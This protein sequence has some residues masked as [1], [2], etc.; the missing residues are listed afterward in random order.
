MPLLWIHRVPRLHS[1]PCLRAAVEL[2][3]LPN[4]YLA[5]SCSKLV[6][7]YTF[8]VSPG[9]EPY[10]LHSK[11]ASAPAW[12]SPEQDPTHKKGKDDKARPASSIFQLFRPGGGKY[13]FNLVGDDKEVQVRNP[14][15]AHGAHLHALCLHDAWRADHSVY[16]WP[17]CSADGCKCC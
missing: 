12:V 9:G 13:A 5:P 16:C 1:T 17:C 15:I 11:V 10:L 2:E 4:D 8:E 7:E 14:A 6:K 3:F